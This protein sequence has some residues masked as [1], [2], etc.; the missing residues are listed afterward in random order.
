MLDLIFE[1]NEELEYRIHAVE[2]YATLREYLLVESILTLMGNELPE[3]VAYALES[4]KKDLSVELH[5][6]ASKGGFKEHM[7]L[8]L[9][10]LSWKR[11]KE[12]KKAQKQAQ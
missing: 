12:A 11:V 2:Y 9:F 6:H 4:L 10:L 5:Y 3:K 1:E 8:E 7:M